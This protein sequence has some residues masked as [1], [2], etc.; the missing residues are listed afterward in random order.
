MSQRLLGWSALVV[1][2]VFG[3]TGCGD[4][5]G[6]PAR[7]LETAASQPLRL[8]NSIGVE[9][10]LI[11]AGT[12]SMGSADGDDDEQPVHKVRLTQPFYLGVHE[13]TNAQWKAVMGEVPSQWQ[14]A[15]RPVEQ[16]SWDDAVKF[17]RKLSALP[18]ERAAGRVYR[19]PTEAEWE[20][21]CRAG[22]KTR[23]SF[24][25]DEAELEEHG[26][27]ND[28]SGVATHPVG[29]K[30]PNAW[31]LYDMH[32]NVWEW[33]ADWYGAYPANAV[34]DPSGRDGGSI[35]V[36]RGGSWLYSAGHCRSADRHRCDP[37]YR[38]RLP[39]L[40][41]CPESVWSR[42]AGGGAV[43]ERAPEGAGRSR[44]TDRGEAERESIMPRQRIIA[45]TKRPAD[46][47][48]HGR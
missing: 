28:N 6:P 42:A 3:A 40:S 23:Y 43:A 13:V 21:A 5:S 10:A 46:A 30:K 4:R 34:A 11:P 38:F 25:D 12:F 17:C 35:R 26:W 20:Y 14:D 32:G 48:M 8:R 7:P 18:A 36:I 9:M 19:L 47:A 33:C 44:A 24:G 16:V 31:G 1:A 37:E 27:F 41:P 39:G 2:V 45:S 29:Q 22:S 15:D